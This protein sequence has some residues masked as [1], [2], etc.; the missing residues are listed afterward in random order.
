MRKRRDRGA[1]ELMQVNGIWKIRYTVGGRRVQESTGSTRREDAVRLLNERLGQVV[2]GRLHA[3]HVAFLWQ[4]LERIILDEHR[5]HR[6]Y[7]KVER[8]VRRHCGRHLAGLKVAAI[9]YRRLLHYKDDRLAEDGSPSTVA[10]FS[11]GPLSIHIGPYSFSNF[12][13]I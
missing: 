6:S 10:F 9:D 1:G 13:S 3:D 4:D 5:L 2:T 8:H 7:E 11:C 12:P